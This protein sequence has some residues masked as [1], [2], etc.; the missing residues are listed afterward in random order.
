MRIE[1]RQHAVDRGCDQLGVVGLVDVV[2]AHLL[3]DVAEQ[4]ELAVGVVHCRFGVEP[5]EIVPGWVASSVIAAPA[6]AP[7]RMS[8]VLRIIREPFQGL[9]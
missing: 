9:D 5:I 6:A 4:M 1:P 3:E 7:T 2:G 8:V